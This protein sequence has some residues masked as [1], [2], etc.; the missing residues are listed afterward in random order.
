MQPNIIIDI[1]YQNSLVV[2]LETRHIAVKYLS[3]AIASE[4]E[5]SVL[6]ADCNCSQSPIVAGHQVSSLPQASFHSRHMSF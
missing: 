3:L 5:G 1:Q 2:V 6:L 4:S